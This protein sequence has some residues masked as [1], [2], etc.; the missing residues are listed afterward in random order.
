MPREIDSRSE[1]DLFFANVFFA[2]IVL[3][4]FFLNITY[5]KGRIR[6][7]KVVEVT[8]Q[9]NDQGQGFVKQ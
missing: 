4:T 3:D 2:N 7:I 9:L 1:V 5:R 6:V 8:P